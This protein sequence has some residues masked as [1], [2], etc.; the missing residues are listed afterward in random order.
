MKI[1]EEKEN[2][3]LNRKEIK[4]IV[5][6]AKNPNFAEIAKDLAGHFKVDESLVKVKKI[7]GK[8]GM[9]TFLITALIYKTAE[10]KEKQ[11]KVKAKKK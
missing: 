2:N 1:L 5:D 8:F 9:G 10:E 6:A 4:V 3:L 7:K 11:N